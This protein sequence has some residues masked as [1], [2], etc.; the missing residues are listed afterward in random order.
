MSLYSLKFQK[1]LKHTKNRRNNHCYI[2]SKA[3]YKIFS[4]DLGKNHHF[5]IF[6]NHHYSDMPNHLTKSFNICDLL[7]KK[8]SKNSVDLHT[9]NLFSI[10]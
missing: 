5:F 6:Q 4:Q 3:V 9:S 1:V 10:K 8:I 2:F 7:Y